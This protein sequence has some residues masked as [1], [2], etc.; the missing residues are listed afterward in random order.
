MDPLSNVPSPDNY[1]GFIA[2]LDAATASLSTRA[3]ALNKALAA[4]S[5]LLGRYQRA[6]RAWERRLARVNEELARHSGEPQTS[7]ALHE[8]HRT[9]VQMESMY[10]A[11]ILRITEKLANIQGRRDAIGRS[12][13]ELEVSRAKL[14]TSRKLS[15]D[16]E[17]LSK[18]LYE[19]A[20]TGGATA[21]IPDLGLRNDLKEAREAVV[22]A[23]ALLEVKGS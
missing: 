10:S 12:L 11:Q 3:R 21:E 16:R 5:L 23:E 9:A 8:L 4:I 17:N 22:L 7:A 2:R 13:L 14:D 15:Q 19:L 20:G 6:L 1:A 18:A